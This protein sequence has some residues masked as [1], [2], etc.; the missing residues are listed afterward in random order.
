MSSSPY[1]HHW[2][3]VTRLRILKRA[4]YLCER[5]FRPHEGWPL[6]VAHLV[7]PPG[8]PGHDADTNLAALCRRC[9]RKEDYESWARKFAAWVQAQYHQRCREKDAGRPLLQ[10]DFHAET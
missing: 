3:T 8:Q 7:I 6:D 4:R 10:E 9:H 2:R 5:C 1:D